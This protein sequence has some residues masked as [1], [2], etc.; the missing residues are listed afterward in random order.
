[1][2][3]GIQIDDIDYIGEGTIPYSSESY[4]DL[5]NSFNSLFCIAMGFPHILHYHI[6][7]WIG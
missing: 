4:L 1:M 5:C 7:L 6:L 3:E 2:G